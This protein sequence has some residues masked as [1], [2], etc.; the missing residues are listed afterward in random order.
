MVTGGSGGHNSTMRPWL[1]R[2]ECR[3]E[4]AA[5]LSLA[6]VVLG[7]PSCPTRPA[8]PVGRDPEQARALT[9]LPK[10]EQD[11]CLIAQAYCGLFEE[12]GKA[13]ESFDDLRPF[14]TA[15]GRNPDDMRVSPNDG[16][17]Y[18]VMWGAD[19]TRGG[20]GNP[21]GLTRVVAHEQTGTGGV[22]AV[23]DTR[24]LAATVTGEEFAQLKF[25]EKRKSKGK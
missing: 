4:R 7:A 2:K 22:R 8:L 20:G 10:A 16:Q 11:L 3:I 23:A 1:S 12:T 9:P 24:G 21:K 14:L 5:L 19:P 13:A 15:R 18:V 6:L 25:I 17:P